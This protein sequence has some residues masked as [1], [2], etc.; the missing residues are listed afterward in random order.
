MRK[1]N[2]EMCLLLFEPF[3][4]GTTFNESAEFKLNLEGDS[5]Q[6][7]TEIMR[8]IPRQTKNTRRC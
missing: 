1:I 7:S 6:A 3:G 2:K 8:C 5:E 4:L